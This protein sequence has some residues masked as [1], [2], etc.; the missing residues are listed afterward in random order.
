MNSAYE[1]T[2]NRDSPGSMTPSYKTIDFVYL[3]NDGVIYLKI[4]KYYR[5][6][7]YKRKILR[8][9]PKLLFFSLFNYVIFKNN[10]FPPNIAIKVYKLLKKNR[11]LLCSIVGLS[12]AASR[13]LLLY[14]YIKYVS[15]LMF[16]LCNVVYYR[17]YN[18]ISVL[19]R[20]TVA[21][22][23]KLKNV[24]NFFSKKVN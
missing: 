4:L 10:F 5:I 9:F 11:W 16:K 24:Y 6:Y 15:F 22:M 19:F 12:A 13:N 20:F 18:S 14:V 23:L 21:L 2:L 8:M 1:F 17:I 7:H 3:R